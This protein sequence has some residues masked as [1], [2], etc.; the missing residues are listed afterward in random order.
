MRVSYLEIYNEEVRDLL[1]RAPRALEIKEA[2]DGGVAVPGLTHF[3]VKS[4]ADIAQVLRVSMKLLQLGFVVSSLR[5]GMDLLYPEHV[6]RT[7]DA[8]G[9]PPTACVEASLMPLGYRV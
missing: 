9:A 4:A 1:A 3:S 2:P 7:W 6:T 5:Q 8:S